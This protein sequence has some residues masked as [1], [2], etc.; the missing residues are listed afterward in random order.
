M[1]IWFRC[2]GNL[3]FLF[4][5]SLLPV[6]KSGFVV[7]LVVFDSKGQFWVV[8]WDTDDGMG[9]AVVGSWVGRM[10]HSGVGG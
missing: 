10:G 6:L 7:T 9:W 1:M 4:F 8:G 2:C 3:D 5:L